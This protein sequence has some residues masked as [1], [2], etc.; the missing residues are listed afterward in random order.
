[1]E[2]G[3]SFNFEEYVITNQPGVNKTPFSPEW[4]AGASRRDA[5]LYTLYSGLANW[6]G[7]YPDRFATA[8]SRPM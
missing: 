4:Y 1:V 8:F 7:R 2:G 3:Y 5:N 6:G